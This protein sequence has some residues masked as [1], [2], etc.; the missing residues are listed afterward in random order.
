MKK[1]LAVRFT[2]SKKTNYVYERLLLCQHCGT[3][4]IRMQDE[5]EECGKTSRLTPIQQ[6]AHAWSRRKGQSSL[7]FLGILLCLAIVSAQTL[8]ALIGSIIGSIVLFGVAFSLQKQLARYERSVHFR[9]FLY[10]E[11]GKIRLALMRE[12][13][14]IAVDMKEGNPKTAY[15]KLR[16]VSYFLNTDSIKR[17]KIACLNQFVLR[18][19]MELELDTL[20]PSSYDYQFVE[21][22]RKVAQ[23]K[24]SLIKK[25]VLDYAVTY[26]NEILRHEN[27]AEI[28]AN[29]AGAALRMKAYVDD[30]HEFILEFLEYLSKERLLR[31]AKLAS[32]YRTEWAELYARTEAL[33]S[34]R[35]SF[36]PDFKGIF[37]RGSA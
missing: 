36:D 15:E 34:A 13:D 16:E 27:G 18:S 9:R 22:L 19:D 29:V 7:L 6:V 24:R 20:V 14:E 4:S 35:Y 11:R 8:P 2:D 25:N 32:T 1:K 26:K 10:A 12:L 21:Y 30:Y 33:V 3:Y 17:R 28:L 37:Q 23:V 31:L 5:C